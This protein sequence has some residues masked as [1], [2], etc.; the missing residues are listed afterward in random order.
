MKLQRPSFSINTSLYIL[1]LGAKISLASLLLAS[2]STAALANCSQTSGAGTSATC[3][4][5]APNPYTNGKIGAPEGSSASASGVNNGNYNNNTVTINAGS[6][7]NPGNSSAISLYNNAT[8][9]VYGTV[10]NAATNA[11]GSYG[12]GGNTIEFPGFNFEVRLRSIC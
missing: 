11:T 6:T 5:N 10:Q 4:T 9:Y 8:I 1:K 3:D 12:T 2:T 7:I